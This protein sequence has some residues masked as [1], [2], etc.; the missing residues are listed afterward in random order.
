MRRPGSTAALFIGMFLLFAG[1]GHAEVEIRCDPAQVTARQG[2][3]IM[4][5]F[6]VRNRSRQRLESPGNILISYHVRDTAGRDVR[7]D[8]RRF[9]LP[10]PVRPGATARFDL[11]VFFSIAPGSYLLEWDLVREGEFWGRDRGWKT[12]TISLRLLP[13]VA[14]AFRKD[15][16]PTFYESGRGLLD[17][18]QYLLR[19]VLRNNEIRRTEILRLRRRQ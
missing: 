18:G 14:P 9:S 13:L 15:Q 4:L 19:Q 2:E 8:N 7:F 1:R 17:R 3:K 6:T 5:H 12:A 11:P 16:L 10:L